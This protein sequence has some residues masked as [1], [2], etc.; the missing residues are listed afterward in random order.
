MTNEQFF[1]KP[2]SILNRLRLRLRICNRKLTVLIHDVSIAKT[3]ELR[4]PNYP[5][6][7]VAYSKRELTTADCAHMSWKHYAMVAGNR[8]F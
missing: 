2:K 5:P 6:V 1:R 8:F 4:Q 7:H 3:M